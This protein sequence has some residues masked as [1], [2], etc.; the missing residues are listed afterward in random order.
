MKSEI[1]FHSVPS[2][3]RFSTLGFCG[4]LVQ[5]FQ[6]SYPVETPVFDP[7]WDRRYCI[8]G[9]EF[10]HSRRRVHAEVDPV[11]EGW[12]GFEEAP[13]RSDDPIEVAARVRIRREIRR[14]VPGMVLGFRPA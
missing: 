5:L 8:V 9:R 4:C 11:G 2:V 7:A 1:T 6:A 10:A 12:L 13:A 14:V 3:S